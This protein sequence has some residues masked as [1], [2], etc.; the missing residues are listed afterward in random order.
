MSDETKPEAN[1][2]AENIVDLKP[3]ATRKDLKD[4]A[5]AFLKANKDTPITEESA[6]PEGTEAS[7]DTTGA[8]DPVLVLEAEL[9]ETKDQLLRTL[10]E[11][12]NIRKRSAKEVMEARVFAIEKFA[13]DLLSVSDNM[14]RALEALPEEERESLSERGKNL[15]GGIEMTQKE[16]HAVFAR[17]NVTAIDAAP[18]DTFDPN[19][20][21]AVANIPSE[22]TSGAIAECFQPGWKIGE[23]VL[24]AAMVAVSSGQ[25]N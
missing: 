9:A 25:P 3:G 10:A 15:L 11:A 18:G 7:D 16:L 4:A 13:A 19:L 1:G 2:D 5:D 20:H 14:T 22:H 12:Q 21:Q 24:R 8:I 17:N 23:R 6:E